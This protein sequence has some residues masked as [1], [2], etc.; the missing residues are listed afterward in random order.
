MKKTFE[1]FTSAFI[2]SAV[3]LSAFAAFNVVYLFKMGNTVEKLSE[4]TMEKSDQYINTKNELKHEKDKM[5][6]M[7]HVLDIKNVLD[8]MGSTTSSYNTMD[9]AYLIAKESLDNDLDPLL[10]LAVIQTE[11]SF[12]KSI[13][14]NK[15]AIGLMQI[16]PNTA[17]YV[18]SMHDHIE[19]TSTQELFEPQTNITIGISYLSY[20]IN[21][22]DNQKYALIAYNMGPTN[23]VR[24]IK[25]GN[26]LPNRYYR[27]VMRNYSYILSKSGRV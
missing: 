20:L 6:F 14:S 19:L 23:L 25:T 27:S 7:A 16:L 24:R 1:R 10:V 4:K 5:S 2:M 13:V 21:K 26:V 17:Q 18:S 9:F 8:D 11:S 22:F 3:V 15:G 12:R